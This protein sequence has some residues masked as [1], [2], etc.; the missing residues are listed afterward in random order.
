MTLAAVAAVTVGA[1]P[2]GTVTVGTVAG[3]FAISAVALAPVTDY[4]LRVSVR[5]LAEE[6]SET[7][8]RLTAAGSRRGSGTTR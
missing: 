2:F 7:G 3:G 6:K 4:T 5:V 8:V 1:V